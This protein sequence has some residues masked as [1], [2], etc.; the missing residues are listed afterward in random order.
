MPVPFDPKKV[1]RI[2]LSVGDSI[3]WEKPGQS[4]VGRL[5]GVK[6]VEYE[7][8]KVPVH[9]FTGPKGEAFEVWES[10]AL[11]NL[12]TIPKGAIVEIVYK[13]MVKAKK[14]GRKYKNFDLFLEDGVELLSDDTR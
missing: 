7:G 4:V 8:K 13:G 5:V 9:M 6:K 11:S 14:G 10:A 2:K 1:K 12:N 3:R